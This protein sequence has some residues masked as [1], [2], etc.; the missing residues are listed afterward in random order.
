[1]VRDVE[2]AADAAL[3]IV[4][5]AVTDLDRLH[6]S[7]LNVDGNRLL[8]RCSLRTVRASA[9]RY[10][11]SRDVDHRER[12]R[13]VEVSARSGERTQIERL[14]IDQLM[15]FC[16]KILLPFGFLQVMINGIV[17]LYVTDEAPRD[18]LL[19]LTSGALLVAMSYTIYRVTKQPSREERVGRMVAARSV[20]S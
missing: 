15:A 5:R 3:G 12:A 6:L 18:I 20:P 7:K 10:I 16:W 9:L 19:A 14:R 11:S 13:V 1:M 17:L 8:L 4:G 2:D